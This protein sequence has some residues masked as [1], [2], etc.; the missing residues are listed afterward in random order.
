M[1]S[2]IIDCDPGHDDAIAILA[3]Y[4][5]PEKLKIIGITTVG[6]NQTL[7]KVTTNAKNILSFI[8]A[9]IPLAS[10]QSGPLVKPLAMGDAVHGEGGMDGPFFSGENYPI[11]SE[12]AVQFLY[13]TIMESPTKVTIA[14]LAPLTN[15]ALLLKVYPEVKDKIECISLMGGGISHGNRT[16]LAEFNVYVDPEAAYIVFKSGLPIIMSGLD[17]TEK[18]VITSDEINGLENKGRVSHL[19]YELLSFY[20]KSGIQFGIQESPIHD[21]CATAYLIS[22]EIFEGTQKYV[23]IITNDG[24]ARGC[25]YT[26][27]RIWSKHRKNV[28]VLDHVNRKK[29]IEILLDSLTRLDEQV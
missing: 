2:I 18:A 9:D 19:V 14:A 4:A 16:A 24:E 20:H 8:H 22:P 26:D 29:L 13:E 6:G 17:V 21:L 11:E 3:A 27:G 23:N 25:T 1:K 10:G 5:N 7:E 15:I 12:H 28:L